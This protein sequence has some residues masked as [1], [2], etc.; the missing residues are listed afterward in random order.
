[1]GQ[2]FKFMFASMLGF[3]LANVFVVLLTI[4]IIAAV[5][6][7]GSNKEVVVEENSVLKIEFNGPIQD[8]AIES[9]FD[10]FNPDAKT[11]G[12]SE[13]LNAIEF[14]KTDER[15]KG[16]YLH[17]QTI[18][19][20]M[21][22]IEELRNALLDFKKSGKFVLS[23]SNVY[24][25]KGYYLASV[26]D[27]V[28]VHPEGGLDF[29]GLSAGIT[30][31]KGTMEKLELEPQI[32]RHGKFKSAI[33]P[34]I[35]DKMSEANREQTSA[36]LTSLWSTMLK[37]ISSTRKIDEGELQ[38]IADEALVRNAKDAITYKLADKTAYEDEVLT[39][40]RKKLSLEKE[41][42]KIK[43]V[44]IG[45]YVNAPTKDETTK[46]KIAVIY[47]SGDIVDGQGE[48]DNVGGDKIAAT[49][50]K[51]RLDEK[52]KAIVLRVN[53]P[54]GS[55]LAS[56][57][58]WREVVLAR[59]AKKPVIVSMG[60]VAAS[61]GY[62]ISCA[63]DKIYASPNTITGSIGVFGVLLN[64]QKMLNNKLGVTIDTV[65]TGKFADMGAAYRPL[66][67]S[68]REIIQQGVEDIYKTFITHVGEGR[69]ISTA[70]VDS[71]GQGR[72]WSGND[73]KRIKL[74]DEFGGLKDA[75]AF[76]AQKAKLEKY[77]VVDYPEKED[78]MKKLLKQLSGEGEN[79]LLKLQLGDQYP[80]FQRVRKAITVKGIQAR[81]PFEMEIY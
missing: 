27:E 75:I 48:D 62:Y 38:R 40:L 3:I 63:A 42:D 28:W 15:I 12:L 26:S 43:F 1:M 73:A 21:A 17:N 51:A 13:I 47:A 19:T 78:P 5:A 18:P 22:T 58:M 59:K 64:A 9:P 4:I 44:G 29:R 24:D 2:F 71:I 11:I 61:G 50:R 30:F 41:T 8:R 33:E 10:A 52:V 35:L 23:Y 45:K 77:R 31:L 39:N 14:A 79:A 36:Y 46:E 65:R 53:S 54:G 80:I 70:E 57:V 74:V 76:A 67:A 7:A 69:K 20:G 68:E 81:I 34:L 56:D 25:Q 55:A 32:I 72:V 49:I 37:G 16:I 66:T 60:D 6:S